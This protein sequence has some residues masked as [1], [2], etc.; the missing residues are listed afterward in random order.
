MVISETAISARAQIPQEITVPQVNV[1][2][3]VNRTK[4]GD[5]QAWVELDGILDTK[6]RGGFYSMGDRGAD[7]L[8]DTKFKIFSQLD[9]FDPTLG[10]TGDFSLGWISWTRQIARNVRRDEFRRQKRQPQQTEFDE[11]RLGEV[12]LEEGQESEVSRPKVDF[13]E[14]FRVKI[15]ELLPPLQKEIVRLALSGLTPPDIA[16]ALG[17]KEGTIRTSLYYARIKLESELIFPAGYGR[18]RAFRG[19]SYTQTHLDR[20]VREGKLEGVKFLNLYYTTPEAVARYKA[21][22]NSTPRQGDDLLESHGYALAYDAAASQAEY[23]ALIHSDFAIKSGGRI[24]IKPED[25]K[26]FRA[27]R[28]KRRVPRRHIMPPHG[29][30][31]P[32]S[33]TNSAR[34][35]YYVCNAVGKGRI[36]AEKVRDRIFV[37]EEEAR[38]ILAERNAKKTSRALNP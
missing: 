2:E 15:D 23:E 25:I 29:F 33:I 37:I 18:L 26:T 9:T 19:E 36:Q 38:R 22:T 28:L 8:Q 10:R 16:G 35:Y 31:D 34:D 3:L 11:N 6:L 32:A 24:Y 4:S 14:L 12:I 27:K 5:K 13:Q 7:L 30:S 20:A 17:K 21:R 1:E